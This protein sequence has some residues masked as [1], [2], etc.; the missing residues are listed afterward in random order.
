MVRLMRMG[1]GRY[2]ATVR[3]IGTSIKPIEA[4]VYGPT[5]ET[6]ATEPGYEWMVSTDTE[7]FFSTLAECRVYLNRFFEAACE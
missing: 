1:P 2:R 5:W 3:P 7:R 4:T 6:H